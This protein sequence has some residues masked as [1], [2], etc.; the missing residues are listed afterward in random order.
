MPK[1]MKIRFHVQIASGG[2]FKT[3]SVEDTISI[4]PK[5]SPELAA[6]TYKASLRYNFS[7]QTIQDF[8]YSTFDSR[9]IYVSSELYVPTYFKPYQGLSQYRAFEIMVNYHEVNRQHDLER[10]AER[11]LHSK[12][13]ATK[14]WMRAHDSYLKANEKLLK[15]ERSL[16]RSRRAE[17][18]IRKTEEIAKLREELEKRTAKLNEE[19]KFLDETKEALLETY[20]NIKRKQERP[21]DEPTDDNVISFSERIRRQNED[22]GYSGPGGLGG[23]GGI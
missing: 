10:R 5:V 18:I 21:E 17:T 15:A 2:R 3:F 23:P 11:L 9:K 12:N 13:L 6:A 19:K 8:E 20:N 14:R 22:G 4:P 7:G 1:A 16:A